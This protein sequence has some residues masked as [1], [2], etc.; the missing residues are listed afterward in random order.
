MCTFDSDGPTTTSSPTTSSWPS[1]SPPSGWSTSRAS[2]SP[3]LHRQAIEEEPL[4]SNA[5]FFVQCA[6]RV[7]NRPDHTTGQSYCGGVVQGSWD[8][9]NYQP[10]AA[11]ILV[12]L[13]G[14]EVG[15]DWGSR[16]GL[17]SYLGAPP[18]AMLA[19]TSTS[20][21]SCSPGSKPPSTASRTTCGHPVT[22]TSSVPT[23]T[24]KSASTPGSTASR[25]SARAT[26]TSP[27]SRPRSTS[28]ATSKGRC[29]AAT[30]APPRWS[31]ARAQRRSSGTF[32]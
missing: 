10:G 17:D 19:T 30:D 31:G 7:W 18:P 27:A 20:S 8:T 15:A 23:R 21:T 28:R 32:D 6:T 12:A 14:G 4:G 22:R 29:A 16:Y 24:S 26:S 9:T 11:G 1:P 2:R 3:P 13:P 5:K 25:A